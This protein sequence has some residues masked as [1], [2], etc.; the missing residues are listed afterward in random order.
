MAWNMRKI[1]G[2]KIA[3]NRAEMVK[4]ELSANALLCRG[5]EVSSFS[6]RC[7]REGV[8]F[9]FPLLDL[10][11]LNLEFLITAKKFL[12]K[13]R[14]FPLS[15]IM[16]SGKAGEKRGTLSYNAKKKLTGKND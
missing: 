8:L 10:H 2:I 1:K 7:R 3:D 14:I 6:L 13:I 4:N 9:S 15:I 5:G 12:P 16:V 11:F